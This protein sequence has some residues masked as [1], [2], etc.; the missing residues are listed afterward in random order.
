MGGGSVAGGGPEGRAPVPGAGADPRTTL[1]IE[2][3]MGSP[4][5]ADEDV[6]GCRACA[7]TSTARTARFV[8]PTFW[9]NSRP[10]LP[11]CRWVPGADGRRVRLGGLARS[12]SAAAGS[13]RVR[14]AGQARMRQGENPRSAPPQSLPRREPLRHH[15]A[16][17]RG[18][19]RMP[20]STRSQC[21]ASHQ[22]CVT[23]HTSRGG[24]SVDWPTAIRENWWAK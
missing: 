11:G 4:E 3:P 17:E 14:H 8:S 16:G 24:V 7:G 22:R 2:D 23:S 19:F 6:R 21:D 13:G 20:E 12:K 10:R 18:A 1:S 5:R 9:G 15:L